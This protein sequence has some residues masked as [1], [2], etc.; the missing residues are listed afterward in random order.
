MI[1]QRIVCHGLGFLYRYAYK[2]V[3]K[4]DSN[5]ESVKLLPDVA[6]NLWVFLCKKKI[7]RCT[8]YELHVTSTENKTKELGDIL[9]Q[10]IENNPQ[11]KGC[12]NRRF[13][14]IEMLLTRDVEASYSKMGEMSDLVWFRL[15]Q[16]PFTRLFAIR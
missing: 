2:Y 6:L 5:T 16:T 1:I 10:N 4:F 13:E 3:G 7:I 14:E 8:F 9:A 11:L 12:G 15:D